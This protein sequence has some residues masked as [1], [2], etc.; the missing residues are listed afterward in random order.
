VASLG[1]RVNAADAEDLPVPEATS[2][3]PTILLLDGHS[4][5]YRA[6]YALPDTLRT[7]TGQLTNA[8]YGFTSML[9]K[10]L[11]DRRPDAVVVAFD[12]GRDVA[13]TAAF[14]EYKANRSTPPDEFRPQ[15]DLIKQV[16]EA[17]RIPV[18]EVAGVEADD[19]L[20]T[21]ADRAIDAGFHS[22]IVTGDRDAMQL[23]GD[24][25]T[26]LYTLRGISE[27][28]EMD[29]AAVEDRYGVPPASY[30]D[31]AALRGDNSDNLPG[32]PGVGDK[33]AAKLVVQFGDVDG[34]YAHLEEVAGKK[35]PAMLAEHE[36]QVRANQRIMRLRRD[37][38]VEADPRDLR[39]T[40]IDAA[41]VRELFGSLEFRALYDRFVDEVLGEQEEA[42]AAGFERTPTRLEAGELAAWLEGV[43]APVA[44]LPTVTGRP[45]HT[46]LEAVAV[47][48]PDRD[49]ASARVDALDDDDLAALARVLADPTV[50]VVT[51]DAKL[52]DHAVHGRGWVVS[53]VTVDTELAAY[54]LNPEQRSFDLERLALQHLQ[55]TIAPVGDDNDG[56]QLALDVTP[57]EGWEER[58]MRAEAT[59]ELAAFLAAE[60]DARGQRDLHD[61]IELPLAPVLAGMER[62]GVAID[63]HVLDDIRSRLAARVT[64]RERE[65]HDHA[66]HTFNVGSGQQLQVVL[67]D[68]L[69]LPKTRRIKTG[70][71]TDAN[72]LQ[73]LL[74]LHPIIEAIMEWRE[75]SKLLTTYVDAL[76]PL[77]DPTTARIHTTLSQTIAATGRLSSSNPNLQNIPVRRDE[78]REIRRAFVPGEGFDQLLVADYSQ[79]ELRIMAHLSGDEGLLDAFASE[80]D[81]HATTAAKVFDLPL[82]AV[83]GP[84]RDRAKAV[85]YG[86]AYGLTPF[87]LGQQLGIPPDEAAEIVTAYFERFP[88]VRSFLDAAVVA[89]TNDGYTTTMFGRRRY[90]P[91]LRSDNRNR[92]QM[93]E[94]MALN[95]PI[96][97]TAADV[98]KLAM[99][100]LARALGTS[101]LRTQLLLQVHDEVVLEV[102]DDERDAAE[103]LVRDTLSSVCELAVPL[104]VDT[105]FGVTWYDAQKH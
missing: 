78:G 2:A 43:T 53:G 50:E 21:L 37:V 88:K 31:L 74:G 42:E 89:A 68:E 41:A 59:L 104:E 64:D 95:A 16:L 13:R 82:D 105:A 27:V 12:K 8:V 36:D 79:I 52:L 75:L 51:H 63:L 47:A 90:L 4:L 87:G 96:Q 34:I 17:L 58:A 32:V 69:E 14:P 25:L 73:N 100:D 5:A 3:R 23:V 38:E 99:I 7:R 44:V 6:F 80:E 61:R 46:G 85:N 19:V 24:H 67:F 101:G 70:Y 81:V 56:D 49:P 40:G 72:A 30:V 11:G 33:T 29:P 62:T 102:P 93:A 26:V 15:V 66:G 98:I 20:A 54:L 28:A 83:D 48:A 18:V 97:G 60:I 35:V 94:R 10:L 86:L 65:V 77:V 9:I 84:L 39:M 91:D 57:D 92:R 22:Y 1:S 103:V 55:R 76:P 45:P 71:S